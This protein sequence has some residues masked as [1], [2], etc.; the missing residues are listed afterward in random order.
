MKKNIE[1]KGI[2]NLNKLFQMIIYLEFKKLILV[3]LNNIQLKLSI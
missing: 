2:E 1:K 3:T